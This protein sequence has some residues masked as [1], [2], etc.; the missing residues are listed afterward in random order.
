M[1]AQ[2]P[3]EYGL[4]LGKLLFLLEVVVLTWSGVMVPTTMGTKIPPNVPTPVDK[5]MRML[6]WRGARSR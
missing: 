6:A 3:V 4:F 2:F 1:Q 5:A